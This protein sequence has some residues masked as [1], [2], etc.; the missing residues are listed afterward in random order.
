MGEMLLYS[1]YEDGNAPHTQAV[2][3][4]LYK[5]ARNSLIG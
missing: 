3:L 4:M 5:E 2:S 1:G